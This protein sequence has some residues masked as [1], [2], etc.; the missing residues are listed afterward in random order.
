MIIEKGLVDGNITSYDQLYLRPL[1]E[2]SV[3][4]YEAVRE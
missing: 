3:P 2:Y 4:L 1:V